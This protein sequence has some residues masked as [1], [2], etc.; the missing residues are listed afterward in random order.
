MIWL[1]ER[2][3]VRRLLALFALAPVLALL[4]ATPTPSPSAKPGALATAIPMMGG[5]PAPV[6]LGESLNVVIFPFTAGAGF[7]GDPG[8]KIANIYKSVMESAGNIKVV[9][10]PTKV[11]NA[12]MLLVA[13]KDRA[14]YYITGALLAMGSG[15]SMV[16]QIVDGRSGVIVY[17]HTVEISNADD[18]ASQAL[19]ARGA[20]LARAGLNDEGIP[21]SQAD[22]TASQ[23]TPSPTKNGATVSL[24]GLGA[25][26]GLFHKHGA[27]PTAR[28]LVTNKPPRVSLV[29]RIDGT[30]SAGDLTTASQE[31]SR[32]VDGYFVTRP[33]DA[34]SST[35]A[36]SANTL[37][38][39]HR[40]TTLLGGSVKTRVE[41]GFR[42]HTIYT[43]TLS[44]YT[45]FGA[46][47]ATQTAENG[48]LATAIHVAVDAYAKAHPSNG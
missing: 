6:K 16:E 20:M 34:Q 31:F 13:Q 22:S 8:T 23:A 10:I 2:I 47:F 19:Q 14:D 15:A 24:G 9:A 11:A 1:P 27:T 29:A 37:C 48:D 46:S 38:G 12:G 26:A 35:L 45:C 28:P 4:A 40:D 17:S 41:G 5:T 32:D 33:I 39:I 43:F 21:V 36:T 44:A 30:L 25:I 3:H 18:A 42:K 7:D